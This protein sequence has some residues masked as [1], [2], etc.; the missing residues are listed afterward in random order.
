M[1]IIFLGTTPITEPDTAVADHLVAAF[2]SLDYIFAAWALL[3]VLVF[4]KVVVFLVE[5]LL[6]A[7]A[8]G[9][10]STF[11]LIT[12]L[13]ACVTCF[14]ATVVAGNELSPI[15]LNSAP[16]DIVAADFVGTVD[17]VG[18]RVLG[19]HGG[20]ACNNILIKLVSKSVDIQSSPATA[21]SWR[22]RHSVGETCADK[23]VQARP[24]VTMATG[25]AYETLHWFETGSAADGNTSRRV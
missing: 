22:P 17:R 3:P 7:G 6:K 25:Q 9:S 19:S 23:L 14:G 13:L 18:I 2:S 11:M 10:I 24:A 12:P 8:N 15:V 16:L 20:I 5:Q 1:R 4:D 21:A